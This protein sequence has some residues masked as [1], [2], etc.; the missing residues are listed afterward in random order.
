MSAGVSSL[1]RSVLRIYEYISPRNRRSVLPLLGLMV[2]GAFSEI[3]TLGAIVPFL[4]LISGGIHPAGNAYLGVLS[5]VL[6]P[7]E[8]VVILGVVF[9]LAVIVSCCVRLWLLWATDKFVYSVAHDLGVELF[10]RTL[11]QPYSFHVGHNSSELLGAISKVQLVANGV[12]MPVMQGTSAG[13]ISLFVIVGLLIVDPVIAAVAGAGFLTIYVIAV[14]LT[15]PPMRRNS[16]VTALAQTERVKVMQ[17]G[18]GGIR[19]V[20][21]D[22]AQPHFIDRLREVEVR[23]RDARIMSAFLAGAPRY[24]IEAAGLALIATLSIVL[25]LRPGGLAASIPLLGALALGSQRLLPLLQ[26]VFNGWASAVGNQKSLTDLL[27]M[28]EREVDTAER[29]RESFVFRHSIEFKD[30]SFSYAPDLPRILNRVN[31]RVPKGARVGIVGPTGSGK[32]TLMDLLLGLLEP[33]EGVIR[34]DGIELTGER[35]L[36]WQGIISHVPQAIYL[37]DASIASNIAF[38]T[39]ESDIATERVRNAAAKAE[40][41]EVID[42]LPASY[43]TLI[44][45]RGVRLSGGQRQRLAIARAL[46]KDAQV[47]VFDE[48]TSALDTGTEAAVMQSIN[49]LSREITVFIIA[50]R[51]STVESCDFVIEISA[52]GAETRRRVPH[53]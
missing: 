16:V 2:L 8:R 4:G 15:R 46:Y 36:G 51:L 27:T 32:S 50:H 53:L 47:L 12:L 44:G 34:V 31:L 25:S 42:R 43:D 39:A 1:A 48:A 52:S 17:E 40:L 26:Q 23:F 37:A 19:D 13:L 3:A 18:L 9:G 6:N 14:A 49:L 21:I 7:A 11:Y 28:L 33:T 22:R 45:E 29:P 5:Q 38:G 30:V 35:R 10:R 41:D 20:L 24:V